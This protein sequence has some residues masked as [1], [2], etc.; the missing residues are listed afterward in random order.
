MEA[1]RRRQAGLPTACQIPLLPFGKAA[2]ARAPRRRG[3]RLPAPFRPARQASNGMTYESGLADMVG[4]EG[5]EPP[6][7]SV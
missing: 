3:A 7:S 5:L 6:T 4:D 1:P 2:N